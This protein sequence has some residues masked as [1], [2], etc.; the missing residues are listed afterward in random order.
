MARQTRSHLQ[1]MRRQSVNQSIT[2]KRPFIT[3]AEITA[4]RLAE[5]WEEICDYLVTAPVNNVDDASRLCAPQI[6][7]QRQN[8]HLYACMHACMHACMRT[9]CMHNKY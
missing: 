4:G 9:S 5:L 8:L 2:S 7:M 1:D 3:A 6:S